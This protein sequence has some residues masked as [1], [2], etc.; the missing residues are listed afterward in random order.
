MPRIEHPEE[1]ALACIR[2]AE[3]C[4]DAGDAIHV[5]KCV[6]HALVL[7][8]DGVRVHEGQSDE[9]AMAGLLLSCAAVSA[10]EIG[11]TRENLTEEAGK[12]FDYV[13]ERKAQHDAEVPQ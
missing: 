10:V 1:V 11:A 6:T 12:A 3:T 2:L 4:Q 13:V 5:L 7:G 8:V 9:E